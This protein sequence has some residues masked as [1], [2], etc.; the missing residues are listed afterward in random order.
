[1]RSLSVNYAL[2]LLI[3]RRFRQ[4]LRDTTLHSH[5]SSAPDDEPEKCDEDQK[6][7]ATDGTDKVSNADEAYPPR[8]PF[9][10][11]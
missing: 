9:R 3:L 4:M 1:M 6:I 8:T 2:Q 7:I 11:L 10:E 5:D